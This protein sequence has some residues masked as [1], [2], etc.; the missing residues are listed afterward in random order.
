MK[1]RVGKTSARVFKK[2]ASKKKNKDNEFK[3]AEYSIQI[4]SYFGVEKTQL[5]KTQYF[6]HSVNSCRGSSI[7]Q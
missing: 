5:M 2:K 1:G 4:E 6:D 7:Q 3:S